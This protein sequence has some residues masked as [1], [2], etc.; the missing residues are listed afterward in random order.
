MWYLAYH[1]IH[2]MGQSGF[3]VEV[4]H[5]RYDLGE[6]QKCKT[7]S[8]SRPNWPK[9]SLSTST[10][11]FNQTYNNTCHRCHIKTCRLL[12]QNVFFKPGS[13]RMFF[14]TEVL[15]FCN[16]IDSPIVGVSVMSQVST[17]PLSRHKS[18]WPLIRTQEYNMSQHALRTSRP[19]MP[20]YGY[21]RVPKFQ[22]A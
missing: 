11:T 20:M 10:C 9:V 18:R 21:V 5:Y 17:Y 3:H 19:M 7:M 1:K 12:L 22:Q 16:H 2:T 15:L 4:S 8:H 13:I 6:Q 14:H